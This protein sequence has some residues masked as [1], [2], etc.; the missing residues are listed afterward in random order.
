MFRRKV[1]KSTKIK[2]EVDAEKVVKELEELISC[3][4]FFARNFK[5]LYYKVY[6]P[7]KTKLNEI[8]ERG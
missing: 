7:A 3:T 2:V 6:I 1:G 8:K 5:E 4:T